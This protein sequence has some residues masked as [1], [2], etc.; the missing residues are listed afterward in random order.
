MHHIYTPQYTVS[1]HKFCLNDIWEDHLR[2]VSHYWILRKTGVTQMTE[3]KVT[4]M[5]DLRG[6]YECNT[7]V[8]LD[9]T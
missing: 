3:L 5:L 1:C 2:R 7:K 4:E 9:R 6:M 8:M